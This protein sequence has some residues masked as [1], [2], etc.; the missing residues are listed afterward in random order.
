MNKDNLLI[1]GMNCEKKL[2]CHCGDVEAEIN[3]TQDLEKL[4]DAIA[5]FAKEKG[6]IMSIVKNE[7]FKILKGKDKLK[8]LQ[9]S[10]KNRKTLFCSNC[11]IY[12]TII[13][14]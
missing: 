4:I 3:I 6:A 9:I 12:H 5:Q 10:Y 1:K 13:Q 2:T 14:G 8:G 7:D 11:R